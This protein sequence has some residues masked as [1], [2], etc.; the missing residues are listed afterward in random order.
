M[1]DLLRAFD[2]GRIMWEILVDGK[3]EVER[4][5]LVH[6]FVGLDGQREVQDIVRV[7]KRGLHRFAERPFQFREVYSVGQG[8]AETLRL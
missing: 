2:L 8:S 7:G 3:V 6:A 1:I 5:S 4:S